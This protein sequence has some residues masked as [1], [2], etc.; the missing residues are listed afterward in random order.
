MFLTV[1]TIMNFYALCGAFVFLSAT[2]AVA[3]YVQRRSGNSGWIDTFWSLGTGIGGLMLLAFSPGG[4]RAWFVA[5]LVVLWSLR[6]GG[7]IAH[8]SKGAAEDPR[9]ADLAREWGPDFPRR[10]FQFLQVQAVCGFLLAVAI[11]LAGTNP[12]PFPALMDIAGFG[13]AL[14]ALVGEAVADAQLRAFRREKRVG[15]AVCEIG[16]WAYSRHP[17]YFFEW[18]FWCAIALLALD[19]SG[20]HLW[21][22]FA[23]V[24]PLMMYW[25]LV[26]ASGIPPLEKYMLESRGDVFR[27]YQARVNAFFP[28]F[29]RGT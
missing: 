3:W 12:A 20:N 7:H 24:A 15:K 6:L 10:L 14:I 8:R 29:R 21:G 18:L 5:G 22:W 25:L 4:G 2:M 23:L 9:Y 17:N 19:F 11:G 16:L 13:V 1:K 27:A 28:G 26:Y